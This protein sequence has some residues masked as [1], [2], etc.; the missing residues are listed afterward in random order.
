[1]LVAFTDQ[2]VQTSQAH[3]GEACDMDDNVLD[4]V[5]GLRRLL[6]DV[7]HLNP[8]KP[9]AQHR[10]HDC[11][12]QLLRKVDRVSAWQGVDAIREMRRKTSNFMKNKQE[13]QTT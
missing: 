10:P 13:K 5:E 3:L 1:M 9:V 12:D 2:T 6:A 7:G 8:V 11:L 4:G